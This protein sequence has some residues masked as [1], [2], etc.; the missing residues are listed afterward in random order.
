MGPGFFRA[1]ARLLKAAFLGVSRWGG[2]YQ[3]N[4]PG[5]FFTVIE[6]PVRVGNGALFYCALFRPSRLARFGV[7][8][9]QSFAVG[10]AV[11]IITHLHHPAVMIGHDGIGIDL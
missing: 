7:L 8:T 6:F 3:R 2:I 1:A 4:R 10:I 9:G 5:V 11:N